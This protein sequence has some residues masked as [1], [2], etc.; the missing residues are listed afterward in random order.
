[1]GIIFL[2]SYESNLKLPLWCLDQYIR[3]DENNDIF[4]LISLDKM[5]MSITMNQNIEFQWLKIVLKPAMKLSVVCFI[6]PS[7]T[8][9]FYLNKTCI[10]IVFK[11][12]FT[13]QNSLIFARYHAAC[14]P[15]GQEVF[16]YC[17]LEWKALMFTRNISSFQHIYWSRHTVLYIGDIYK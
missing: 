1:M 10:H 7:A 5:T 15:G 6:T 13:P 17:A 14:C 12:F 4:S 2:L 3:Y 8:I 16:W 11:I 9:F